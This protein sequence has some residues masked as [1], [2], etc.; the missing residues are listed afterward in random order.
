MGFLQSMFGDQ[1]G[2][3]Y[4][5]NGVN[6]HDLTNSMNNVM[7]TQAQQN[8]LLSALQGQNGIGNQSQI[9]NQQQQLL[10]Q[11]AGV[12]GVG[13]QQ[14]AL[15]AQLQL[16]QQQQGT[17]GQY[18]NLAN[19]VGPNPAQA[20]LAQ[21][22]AANVAQTGALMAGQRGASQNVGMLARQA[23]QQGAQ[24]QQQA[25]G[26]AATLQAQQQLAGL[27]GL[28]AQQQAI[29]ATN[30][31]IAGIGANQ[32]GQQQA[33]QTNLA[34]LSTQQ[35]GQQLAAS[36][37]VANTALGNQ[38]NVYGLQS[39]INTTNAGL[40]QANQKAQAGLIGGI[41]GSAG[42][43]AASAGGTASGAHGGEVQKYADGGVINQPQIQTPNAYGAPPPQGPQS[44][45][46]KYFSG[47][48]GQ[49]GLTQD[50]GKSGESMGQGAYQL[51]KLAYKGAK[52]LFGGK[53]EVPETDWKNSLNSLNNYDQAMTFDQVE[54]GGGANTTLPSIQT[55][56]SAA[57]GA[58]DAA[59]AASATGEG[60]VTA[61]GTTAGIQAAN[62][63][64]AAAAETAG[65]A[66]AAEEGGSALAALLVAKGGQIE[67]GYSYSSPDETTISG[68][69]QGIMGYLN[70]GGGVGRKNLTG[71]GKVKAG[72]PGQKA[73]KSG[74][75]Y[76][77][78]KIPA[79]LSEGE[80]VIPRSVM[81]SKD[82]VR[83]G[84]AFIQAVLAKKR[85]RK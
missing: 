1:T 66:A 72:A 68:T 19:G 49:T 62:A 31:S 84:A 70:Q 52:S 58:S 82:P 26:Q 3:G 21:N 13:N 9:F 45:I 35:T 8:S 76:S 15:L 44:Y 34:N 77:N 7:G 41:L 43:G 51:G 75:S 74:D 42:A 25:V 83:N 48:N 73:V 80:V 37:A 40:A 30:Q 2:A 12:N 65:T 29:G 5:A 61:G 39:N 4:T 33:Q 27:Q 57:E 55:A 81:M 67:P 50:T 59:S 23:G 69:L 28:T 60:A 85:V 38:A 16:A 64:A 20:Q 14:N 22:T 47:Q 53:E 11:Q 78:D 32:I 46:G 71:G 6:Q 54:G 10:N 36:Q 63:A 24:T 56:G 79:V 18:Q 17:A